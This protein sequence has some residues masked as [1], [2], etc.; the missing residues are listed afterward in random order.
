MLRRHSQPQHMVLEALITPQKNLE[1][2][3]LRSVP[4]ESQHEEYL[5]YIDVGSNLL[6]FCL[7]MN[8]YVKKLVSDLSSKQ[9]TPAPLQGSRLSQTVTRT[10]NRPKIRGFLQSV[11]E[12]AVC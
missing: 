4:R 10:Q 6:V 11:D 7:C 12:E 5:F 2:L 9:L 8:V 3:T 1:K